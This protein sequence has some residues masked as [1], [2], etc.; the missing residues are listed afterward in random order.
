MHK[1]LRNIVVEKSKNKRSR[2]EIMAAIQDAAISEFATN[3]LDGT[4]TQAIAKRAGLSKAQ[5]HYYIESKDDLYEKILNMVVT[6]WI[7]I[8]SFS[9]VSLGPSVVLGGYI[10]SK[11]NF[12]FDKP[13]LS[14]IFASEVM[15]GAPVLSALMGRPRERTKRAVKCIEQW[16]EQGLMRRVDPTL[17]ML[18]L[19]SITQHYADFEFQT[20]Y[21]MR[22][23]DGE[24]M[25]RE[26][27]IAEVTEFV[28]IGCG[29]VLVKRG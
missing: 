15:R 29:I 26:H 8:F 5:L 13:M 4:S 23:K 20:R 21:M 27:I 14:R 7:D 17:L 2:V 24:P 1:N 10:R 6:E 19:W 16:I 28:M 18:N 3:G 12:S 9:D 11:L 25:D 22:L